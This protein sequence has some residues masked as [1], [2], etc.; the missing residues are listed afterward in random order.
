[1]KTIN[2]M[3]ERSNDEYD[4]FK[5]IFTNIF[6]EIFIPV[7]KRKDIIKDAYSNESQMYY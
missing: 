7:H 6:G 4:Q 2:F 1:M 5:E 3:I